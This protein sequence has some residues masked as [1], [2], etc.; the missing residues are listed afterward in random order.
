MEH[1]V[2][3]SETS[4]QTTLHF[5][6]CKF[7][8]PEIVFS[9]LPQCLPDRLITSFLAMTLIST[10]FPVITF[11]ACSHLGNHWLKQI[12]TTRTILKE[13]FCSGYLILRELLLKMIWI[14]RECTQKK[15]LEL[16]TQSNMSNVVWS[17]H[18]FIFNSNTSLHK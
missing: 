3:D 7:S 15:D 18:S 14:L 6:I 17:C 13:T 4:M 1:G 8:C 10:I 2:I 11:H 5:A 12:K 9:K 16:I